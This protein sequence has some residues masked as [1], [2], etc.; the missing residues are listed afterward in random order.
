MVG[1]PLP[2]VEVH[3][4]NSH[5][6][7]PPYRKLVQTFLGLGPPTEFSIEDIQ[8]RTQSNDQ[9]RKFA[10]EAA[11]HYLAVR[12]ERGRYV[13]VNPSVAVRCW[14]IPSYYA[15]L[16]ALHDCLAHL[17]VEHAFACLAAT[18]ETDLVFDRPW[19]V[20]PPE[21][22]RPLGAIDRFR[23][24]L[25]GT[26]SEEL[27]TFGDSFTVP[28]LQPEQTALILAATS[29]PRERDAARDILADRDLDEQRIRE[30]NALGLELDPDVLESREPEIQLPEFVEEQRRQLADDL[31]R[32][33][34]R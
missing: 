23:H 31:L 32:E 22:D 21:L 4:L 25:E 16:L 1:A 18:R 27:R 10:S 11:G 17:E 26:E 9:A 14:G 28:V 7:D 12:V 15:D 13:A 19:L 2:P 29:L 24:E 5:D 8:E 33:G 34:E 3:P 20:T 30:F 6:V